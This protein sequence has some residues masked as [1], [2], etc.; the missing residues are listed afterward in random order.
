M[1]LVTKVRGNEN[2]VL[3]AAP[4]EEEAREMVCKS[5]TEDYLREQKV[6][7]PS[8]DDLNDDVVVEMH[9]RNINQRLKALNYKLELI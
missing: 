1:W 6:L 8:G 5:E 3:G 7:S 4:T 9:I 2:I